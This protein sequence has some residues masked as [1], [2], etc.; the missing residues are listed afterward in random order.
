MLIADHGLDIVPQND[1][2]VDP[3]F[4]G[5]DGDVVPRTHAVNPLGKL[6]RQKRADHAR[7]LDAEDRV[8]R[9]PVKR[10]RKLLRGFARRL[11]AVFDSVQ[12]DVAADVRMVGGEMPGDNAEANPFVPACLYFLYR[13]IH[14]LSFPAGPARSLFGETAGTVPRFGFVP[15]IP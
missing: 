1:L 9:G 2:I 7:S 15:I 13:K 6:L 4:G 10:S 14:I 3:E 8:D 11:E 5:D 12:V